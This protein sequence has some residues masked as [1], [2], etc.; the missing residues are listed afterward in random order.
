MELK[1]KSILLLVG[2][3]F[4]GVVSGGLCGGAL[5]GKPYGWI[6]LQPKPQ[7]PPPRP[8]WPTRTLDTLQKELTLNAEQRVTVDK[9]V[10][11][12]DEEIRSFRREAMV[13][14]DQRVK[15]LH[16]RISVVLTAEQKLALADFQK[17]EE[18]ERQAR[19]NQ[20]PASGPRPGPESGR[21]ATP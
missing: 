8:D 5:A 3:F 7:K 20:A 12:A 10:R 4:A 15:A 9:L 11:A 16:D 1:T 19:R 13:G 2:I 17:R 18:D 21:P 14:V 6:V